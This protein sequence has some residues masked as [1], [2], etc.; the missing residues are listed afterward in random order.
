MVLIQRRP[1]YP[2]LGIPEIRDRIASYL[3]R[4]DCLSCIRVSIEWHHYFLRPIWETIDFEKD[5][6]TFDKATSEV[7]AKYG[8]FI[9]QVVNISDLGHLQAL[10]HSK[11]NALKV[12]KAQVSV[13]SIYQQIL[14]DTIQRSEGSLQLI[15]LFAEPS[16]PDTLMEQRKHGKHYFNI[17]YTISSTLNLPGEGKGLTTLL[18]TRLCL[19]RESFSSLLQRC[20]SLRELTLNQVSLFNHMPSLTL[21]TGSKLQC[22][23]A[24]F[25]QVW[26]LDPH[27]LSAPS[28]LTHF[29]LLEKWHVPS[30]AR[31]CNASLA[32]MRQD[33]SRYCLV[34]KHIRFDQGD[35]AMASTLLAKTFGGLETCVLS[36]RVLAASTILGLA[37]HQ[38]SLT[39]LYITKAC[40]PIFTDVVRE[41]GTLRDAT[42]AQWL[43]MIPRL[44]HR[45]RVLSLESFVCD[46]ED[47]ENNVWACT[48]LQELG[49]CV[50]DLDSVQDIEACIKHVCNQ[51]RAPRTVDLERFQNS[52]TIVARTARYLLRFKYLKTVCL[53]T[54]A[55]SLPSPSCSCRIVHGEKKNVHPSF[56]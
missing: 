7:L 33:I 1:P 15:D 35:P 8:G 21:F 23:V 5:D 43:Y 54:Q 34:L 53:G 29:P 27:D 46:I 14:S 52:E 16:I 9:S 12:I 2:F 25:S 6:A 19:S 56:F 32:V 55:Y 26:D 18:L 20:P 39:S 17:S 41:D 37:A 3:D 4:K 50:K 31:S 10:Q 47:I 24:S 40:A 28:L 11:I 22:L 45:L 13:S 38:N 36:A 42:T 49:L 51:R 44:C 30:L 48:D